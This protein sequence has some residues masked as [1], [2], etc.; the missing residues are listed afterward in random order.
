MKVAVSGKGGVGKTMFVSLLSTIFSESGYT[1]LAID[2]DPNA[3]L[4]TALGFPNPEKIT[5]ISEMADLIEE[6][7]GARPGQAA[8]YFKL[9]PK[10]DD[11]PEN[12]WVEH[13]GIKLM[14]MGRLKKGGSGCYCPENALLEALVSHLLLQRDEV[15]IMDMEAGVEHFGRATAKAVDELIVVVEPGRGSVET[16][17]RIRELA[18]D[19]GL[20]SIKVVANKVRSE[21]DREFL[22]AA[23][24]DFEFLG[25]IPYDQSIIEAGLGNLSL[26]KLSSV[27][28]SQMKD[29][30][31]RLSDGKSGIAGE[32]I[33]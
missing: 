1:V 28:I 19:I 12:Y 10:V 30:A 11:I 29:I 25:F 24:P 23:M 17:Y 6:R 31:A 3:T 33:T 14:V 20:E 5:P 4:A 27:V 26:S 22:L 8:P 32:P 13:N 2:A 18:K 9:N 7:T 21:K 16:A 15:V